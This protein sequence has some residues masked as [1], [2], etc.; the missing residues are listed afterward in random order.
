MNSWQCNYSSCGDTAMT[1]V[2]E[3]ADSRQFGED[4]T[5]RRYDGDRQVDRARE[6]SL[7]SPEQVRRM[8][9]AFVGIERP[10]LREKIY[11]SVTEILGVRDA[12]QQVKRSF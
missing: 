10:D 1:I 8:I 2:A 9:Q 7:P 5:V 12:S 3:Y 11:K 6:S 4:D